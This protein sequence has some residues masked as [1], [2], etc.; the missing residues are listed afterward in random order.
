MQFVDLSRFVNRADMIR[1]TEYD[2]NYTDVITS[3][4][5]DAQN[6]VDQVPEARNVV[7]DVINQLDNLSNMSSQQRQNLIK[8]A[9]QIGTDLKKEFNSKAVSVEGYQYAQ[10]DAGYRVRPWWRSWR[11]YRNPYLWYYYR[12]YFW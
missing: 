3:V 4:I 9:H 7:N 2:P 6:V 5:Q 1:R 8:E 10:L 11:G 12:P